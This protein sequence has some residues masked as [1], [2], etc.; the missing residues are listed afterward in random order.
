ME[1]KKYED[2]RIRKQKIAA[3]MWS[4]KTCKVEDNFPFLTDLKDEDLAVL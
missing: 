1:E 4:E 3:Q 2:K